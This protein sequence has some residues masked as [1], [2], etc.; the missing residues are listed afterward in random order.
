MAF[1]DDPQR[2][3]I[4]RRIDIDRLGAVTR[5]EYRLGLPGV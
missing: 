2:E 1:L 3:F 5:T 4:A